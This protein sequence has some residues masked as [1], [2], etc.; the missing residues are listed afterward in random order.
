MEYN[1]WKE[2]VV[3]QIYPKSFYDSNEDGIGDLRGIMMKLPY[4]KSM[5]ITTIWICP[6]NKSPMKDNGYDVADYYDIDP[7]F[8][9]MQDMEELLQKAE[10][11]GI[12]IIMDM[13][14][15]HTS[16]QHEWFKQA[17]QDKN[18]KYRNYYIFKDDISEL[19]NLRANFGGSTWTQIEDGSYYFHTFAVEQPDLNWENEEL[20]EEIYKMLNWWLDKGIAGFRM[21]AITYI[22]KNSSFPKY[23]ADG[24]DGLKDVSTA[25]LN[26]P[27]IDEL[28]DELR[29]RTYGRKD[30]VTVAE[31]PG[32][33]SKDLHKYIGESGH[34]SM[35]FDFSYTDIDIVPGKT[36]NHKADWTFRDFKNRLFEN[37]RRVQEAGWAANY[38]ENHDHPRSINKYF[39]GRNIEKYKEKMA[40]VLG[41]LFFFLRGT[42]FIYQ[43][44]ELGIINN[45]FR[46]IEEFDDIN[47]IDQYKRCMEQGCSEEEA[48]EAVNRRSRDQ[49]RMPMQWDDSEYAGFSTVEPWLCNNTSCP[50]LNVKSELNIAS[51]VLNYYKK[52]I[53]L[54]NQSEYSDVLVHGKFIEEDNDNDYI[55]SYIRK[56]G[57]KT[58]HILL[59]MDEKPYNVS[60]GEVEILLNNYGN[61]GRS[62]VETLRAYEAI[63]WTDL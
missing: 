26:Q 49:S 37:Q 3:Y 15:N 11:Y 51:S 4:L 31:A 9:T 56:M 35:I 8:G 40:T 5:G 41:T 36:W 30:Y 27:G 58:V 60:I 28:L 39:D 53:R 20:K 55:L 12:S 50:E 6:F 16:N 44:E 59:N 62:K 46:S 14:L 19:S 2:A 43:G 1:W 61:M 10:E 18:S 57:D 33:P 29:A 42:P 45:E 48:M 47:S 17:C 24:P 23:E 34:F 32:V 54:R 22:K 13:V 52:M 63:V 7:Q 38:L 25:C 21:D